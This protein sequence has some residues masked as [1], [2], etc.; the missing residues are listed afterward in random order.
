MIPPEL[1]RMLLCIAGR[2]TSG[3][4]EIA[5]ALVGSWTHGELLAFGFRRTRDGMWL[6]PEQWRTS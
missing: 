5:E 6:A 2:R 4:V 3:P 1:R